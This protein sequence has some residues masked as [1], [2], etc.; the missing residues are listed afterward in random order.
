ML[1][2]RIGDKE[3]IVHQNLISF[4]HLARSNYKKAYEAYKRALEV[5]KQEE[6]PERYL[7]IFRERTRFLKGMRALFIKG[8]CQDFRM[9]VKGNKCYTI[10]G[11]MCE[12][13]PEGFR[14]RVGKEE[15]D[16]FSLVTPE[17]LEEFEKEANVYHQQRPFKKVSFIT[18]DHHPGNRLMVTYDPVQAES[19][20]SEAIETE[21]T[22]VEV[23]GNEE[24]VQ[25]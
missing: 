23:L 3:L 18:R 8:Q 5:F 11:E 19:S 9:E 15:P 4:Y 1:T 25:F 24:N 10:D 17:I 2:N 12:A 7:T 6:S 21:Q 20:Q 16:F 22:D 13:C 14:R